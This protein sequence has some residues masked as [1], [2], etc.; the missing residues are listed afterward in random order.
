MRSKFQ[1]KFQLLQVASLFRNF[2]LAERVMR[3]YDCNPVSQPALP[4]THQHPMWQAWVLAVDMALSQLP[5]ILESD[6]PYKAST[7]FEEQ[8]TVSPATFNNS[9]KI[10]SGMKLPSF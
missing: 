8:L 7:F 9:C 1:F 2:L 5:T 10:I 6:A 4:A 3:S